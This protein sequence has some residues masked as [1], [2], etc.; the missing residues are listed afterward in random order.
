MRGRQKR[1][2]FL[3][4]GKRLLERGWRGLLGQSLTAQLSHCF[5]YKK[6]SSLT[7]FLI[8]PL[9]FLFSFFPLSPG[10]FSHLRLSQSTIANHSVLTLHKT[11]CW[12]L[13]LYQVLPFY[14]PIIVLLA[15]LVRH[16]AWRSG[17]TLLLWILLSLPFASFA[18]YC[19][20]TTQLTFNFGI[21][22]VIKSFSLPQ[23]SYSNMN[24]GS[25]DAFH[26][27]NERNISS[28]LQWSA[29][30]FYMSA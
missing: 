16:K 5:V 8:P 10:F 19:F 7:D 29:Q 6:P 30:A 27:I 22:L 13:L 12:R 28:L 14:S 26:M 11:V 3:L 4:P 24:I 1:G 20:T 23:W 21:I 25:Q 18:S 15:Y 17:R 2:Q 9:I